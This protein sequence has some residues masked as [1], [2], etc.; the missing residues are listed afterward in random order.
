VLDLGVVARVPDNAMAAGTQLVNFGAHHRIFAAG[1]TILVVD[2][3][4][5]NL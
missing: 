5:A 1:L 2:Y 3:Q 4:E